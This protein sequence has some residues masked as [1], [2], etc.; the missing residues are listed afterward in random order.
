MIICS[1]SFILSLD[2]IATINY[3]WGYFSWLIIEINDGALSCSIGSSYTKTFIRF[4][5]VT[6]NKISSIYGNRF[7]SLDKKRGVPVHITNHTYLEVHIVY[8]YDIDALHSVGSFV[9][10]VLV[11]KNDGNV[12]TEF[13]M[14]IIYLGLSYKVL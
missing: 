5:F 4:S 12:T 13:I 11:I 1:K 2:T 14:F 10:L 8:A 9:K 3:S 6:W 7:R